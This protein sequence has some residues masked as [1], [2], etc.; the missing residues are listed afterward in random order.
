MHFCGLPWRRKQRRNRSSAG[1]SPADERGDDDAPGGAAAVGAGLLRVRVGVRGRVVAFAPPAAKPEGV[2][3]EE[4]EV[5]GQ[6]QQ[7]YGAEQ[8]NGLARHTHT[9]KHTFKQPPGQVFS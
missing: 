7:G 9:Q 8:Q 5:Q 1:V 6:A 3:E 2:E 4:E